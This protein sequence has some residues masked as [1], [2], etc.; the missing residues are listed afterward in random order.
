MDI[1]KY[2]KVS[3][4]SGDI[5]T[6]KYCFKTH[7]SALYHKGEKVNLWY[8]HSSQEFKPKQVVPAVSLHSF[9]DND[10]GTLEVIGCILNA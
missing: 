3:H 10:Y 1:E 8:N 2:P 6:M 4:E 7:K 9:R 5:F